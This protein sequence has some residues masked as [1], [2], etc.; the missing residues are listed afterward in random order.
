LPNVTTLSVNGKPTTVTIPNI[1]TAIGNPAA[2]SWL[3][4]HFQNIFIGECSD[5]SAAQK[6]KSEAHFCSDDFSR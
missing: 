3:T 1:V 4:P 2:T 6:G 5:K